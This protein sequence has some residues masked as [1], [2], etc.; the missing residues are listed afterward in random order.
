MKKNLIHILTISGILLIAYLVIYINQT[1]NSNIGNYDF[2]WGSSMQYGYSNIFKKYFIDFFNS[3]YLYDS[4]LGYDHS[5]YVFSPLNPFY[6][7]SF[8]GLGGFAIDLSNLFSIFFGAYFIYKITKILNLDWIYTYVL[9][10]FPLTFI[11]VYNYFLNTP[12][13]NGSIL[14]SLYILFFFDLKNRTVNYYFY[15]FFLF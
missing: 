3:F 4:E 12:F 15:T 7:L 13:F 8:L 14:L 1:Y 6:F 10:I 2:W 9:I 5:Y 11:S